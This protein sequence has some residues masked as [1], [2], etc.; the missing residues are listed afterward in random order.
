MTGLEHFQAD[1]GNPASYSQAVRAGN[2]IVTC[3][4][5]GAEPGGPPVAFETQAETALSRLLAVIEAAGGGVDTI[6]RINCYLASMNDFPAYDRIYRSL[7][8]VDPKPTRTTVQIGGFVAPLL[9]E[10]DA[11]AVARAS[12]S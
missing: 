1:W 5:L 2:V 10:V 4:Q 8:D 11:I 12:V 6:L 7:I 9:V 3:G